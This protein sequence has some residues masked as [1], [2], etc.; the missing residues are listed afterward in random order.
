MSLIFIQTMTLL[1]RSSCSD[2]V[3][4]Y[5]QIACASR[6]PLRCIYLLLNKDWFIWGSVPFHRWAGLC[7]PFN[8]TRHDTLRLTPIKRRY[9]SLSCS[10][11]LAHS[12]ARSLTRLSSPLFPPLCLHLSKVGP[13]FGI[14]ASE[15]ATTFLLRPY[16]LI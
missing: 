8:R 2:G 1:K 3:Y 13:A 9:L 10:L 7:P 4:R 5:G 16:L 15:I 11:S 6:R 14:D 12:T